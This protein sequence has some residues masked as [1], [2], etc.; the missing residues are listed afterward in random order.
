MVS[1]LIANEVLSNFC[2]GGVSELSFTNR[3][4]LRRARVQVHGFVGVLQDVRKF[5]LMSAP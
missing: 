3:K 5:L 1:L 2:G 4:D